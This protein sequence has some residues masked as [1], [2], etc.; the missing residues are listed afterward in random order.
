MIA[1]WDGP[2]G[3]PWS[4][5]RA[6]L[7]GQAGLKTRAPSSP[8][9]T[10]GSPFC[11]VNPNQS[12]STLQMPWAQGNRILNSS[13]WQGVVDRTSG[14]GETG[15]TVGTNRT[16]RAD[17]ISKTRTSKTCQADWIHLTKNPIGPIGP[18]S[19]IGLI[20]HPLIVR[21]IQ[22]AIALAIALGLEHNRAFH[23]TETLVM[24]R[25]S[26]LRRHGRVA[27]GGGLLNR[28]RG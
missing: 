5:V 22:N 24:K 6:T 25:M 28:C 27:E 19:P 12:I 13:D 26:N 11:F 1:H 14:T 18:I 21:R 15:R 9:C 7:G 8:L 10:D 3:Y 16:N 2:R 17:R 4:V 23:L 20:F